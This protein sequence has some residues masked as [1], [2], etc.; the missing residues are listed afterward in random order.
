VVWFATRVTV[1]S[2]AVLGSRCAMYYGLCYVRKV[3]NEEEERGRVEEER[4]RVQVQ[5]RDSWTMWRRTLTLRLN[6]S[7]RARARRLAR[8]AFPSTQST[9]FLSKLSPFLDLDARA[10]CRRDLKL[11]TSHSRLACTPRS[12]P[13]TAHWHALR[14]PWQSD[15]STDPT[16]I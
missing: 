7:Q 9:G 10:S 14:A 8:L 5:E 16:C 12:L 15:P 2:A 11:K 1:T 6:F 13:P 4:E 3:Q